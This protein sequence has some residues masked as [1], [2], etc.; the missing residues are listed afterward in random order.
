MND[1]MRRAR[2]A[3]IEHL[4]QTQCMVVEDIPSVFQE[5]ELLWS[6]GAAY[7]IGFPNALTFWASAISEDGLAVLS[8]LSWLREQVPKPVREFFRSGYPV[9]QSI[10]Q[11]LAVAESAGYRALTTY[12]LPKESWVEGYYDVLEP[13]AR[14]LVDHPDTSV[15]DFAVETIKQVKLK[16][17]AG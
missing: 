1:L 6:E 5:I 15:R 14:A 7:N 16:Q 13:R 9:M 10:Q 2:E 11:K 4:V 8:E 12:T 17:G 3:R